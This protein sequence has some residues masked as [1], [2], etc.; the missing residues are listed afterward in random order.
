MFPAGAC[1]FHVYM[2]LVE[3]ALWEREVLTFLHY[4]ITSGGQMS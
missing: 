4:L 1:G 2:W 3:A